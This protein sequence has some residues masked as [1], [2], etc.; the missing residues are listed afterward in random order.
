MDQT[1]G[2]VFASKT[3]SSDEIRRYIEEHK[4]EQ[5]YF[6]QQD[7][8]MKTLEEG[9]KIVSH[10]NKYIDC[11]VT[12]G[13]ICY[14]N[15][16]RGYLAIFTQE[17]TIPDYEDIR[18]LQSTLELCMPRRG[19]TVESTYESSYL[20]GLL[21]GKKHKD[22]SYGEKIY[23]K[24]KQ[25]YYLMVI[26]RVGAE[27]K[28]KYRD[29]YCQEL[30]QKLMHA[31]CVIW[32]QK[33]II[34]CSDPDEVI[35]V[36]PEILYDTEHVRIGISRQFYNLDYVYAYARQAVQALQYAIQK[37]ERILYY[38]EISTEILTDI[39]EKGYLLETFC[40]SEVLRASEYDKRYHT[41]HIETIQALVEARGSQKQAG[42]L[43]GL[44]PNTMKY[45]VSQLKKLFQLDIN[46]Y[47]LMTELPLSLE[48]LKR[49]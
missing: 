38:D 37:K 6:W 11:Y 33:V 10:Y 21:E 18:T 44:H 27:G 22:L 1:F 8:R 29:F 46:D 48:I 14:S 32:N 39:L 15:G 16:K 36:L 5:I 40:R 7:T 24:L 12:C 3:P 20:L 28:R 34:L 23:K 45:R 2:I 26:Q 13:N 19:D 35:R 25:E 31:V 41:Q 47:K 49:L 17:D 42:E 43:L 9:Q 30:S 4:T